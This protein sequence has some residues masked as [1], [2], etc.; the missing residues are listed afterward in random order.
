VDAE[1]W[2][3]R[4]RSSGAL[5]SG[6]VNPQ[7]VRE[8]SD[9]VPGTALD[10]GCGE[11][12]DA[13][14]LAQRGWQVTAVDFSAVALERGTARAA[15]LGTGIARRITWCHADLTAW[16]PAKACYDLVSAQFMH[17]PKEPREA[18][19]RRLASAVAPAGSLLLVAHHPS[20]MQT[21]VRRPRNP[22]VYFTSDDVAGALDL[23]G[24]GIV[25]SAVRSRD[26]T[27]PDGR[28]VRVH[29]TV[30]RARRQPDAKGC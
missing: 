1:F 23:N 12:A 18:L 29:D 25:T 2:D 15:E 4:Y 28:T 8:A 7:L 21:S 14:W 27:G 13:I 26:A 22:E 17:L 30:M 11:G 10:A 24:W 20:D 16:I 6:E 5:W 19:I 9:L 3:E